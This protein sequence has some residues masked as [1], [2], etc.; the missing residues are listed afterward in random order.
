VVP[1]DD[2]PNARL[3]IS[4]IVLDTLRELKLRYPQ[5]TPEQRRALPAIRRMLSK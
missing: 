1:A 3:I 5:P 2:K 4:Q